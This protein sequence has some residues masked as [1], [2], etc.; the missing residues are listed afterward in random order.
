MFRPLREDEI[1]PTV[2]YRAHASEPGKLKTKKVSKSSKINQPEDATVK[3]HKKKVSHI[4]AHQASLKNVFLCL[5]FI[6]K[7]RKCT[8]DCGSR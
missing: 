1:L 8:A 3:K 6:E 5:V 4:N 7:E 2:Q